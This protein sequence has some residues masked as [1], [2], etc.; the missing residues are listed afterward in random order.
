MLLLEA[1][2][3]CLK[4]IERGHPILP[5]LQVLIALRFYGAGTSDV[6]T[7]DPVNMSQASV[8]RINARISRMVA[9][10]LFPPLVK[11]PN[12][13]KVAM[14]MEEF[15]ATTRFLGESGA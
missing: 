11:W 14:T 1:L 15:R 2:L 8:S 10:A 6:V 5:L 13:T 9:D 4:D 12:A 7:E 3:L